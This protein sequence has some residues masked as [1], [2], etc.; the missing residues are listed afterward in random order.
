MLNVYFTNYQ[1]N[2]KNFTNN[3]SIKKR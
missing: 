2:L 1:S 3:F